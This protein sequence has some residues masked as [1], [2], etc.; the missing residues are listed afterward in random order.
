MAQPGDDD[1]G[2]ALA[3]AEA[4][5]LELL[6]E[7]PRLATVVKAEARQAG[8]AERTLWRAKDKLGVKAQKD[9]FKGGWVWSLPKAATDAEA[10]H[11]QEDGSL[12]GA[13]QPSDDQDGWGEV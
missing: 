11:T 9:G 6:R 4:L 12:G 3:E 5:L 10:C 7:G 8:I 1:A 13:W 2:G